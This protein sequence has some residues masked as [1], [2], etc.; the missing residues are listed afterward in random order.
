MTLTISDRLTAVSGAC[1]YRST[2]QVSGGNQPGTSRSWATSIPNCTS[3]RARVTGTIVWLKHYERF[4]SATSRNFFAVE[5]TV[6]LPTGTITGH[7]TDEP[8]YTWEVKFQPII[9]EPSAP[10]PPPPVSGEAPA[11]RH[12]AALSGQPA[13][14]F[15]TTDCTDRHGSFPPESAERSLAGGRKTGF[16]H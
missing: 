1:D 8:D 7:A 5:G 4:P 14:I 16:N 9:V 10:A 6:D 15:L 11:R 13:Q 3:R 12:G 2:E